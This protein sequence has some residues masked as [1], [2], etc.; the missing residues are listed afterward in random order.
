MKT[1][2][3]QVHI[4]DCHLVITNKDESLLCYDRLNSEA[5]AGGYSHWYTDHNYGSI[6]RVCTLSEL[7][8]ALD[9]VQKGQREEK[10][11]ESVD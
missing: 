4:T 9:A 2:D 1:Y 5:Y 8:L 10:E 7:M 3:T 6:T 11:H